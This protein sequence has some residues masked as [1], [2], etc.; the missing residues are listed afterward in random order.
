MRVAPRRVAAAA[1][2]CLLGACGDDA[3]PVPAAR[4]IPEPDPANVER[5]VFLVGD[6]GNARRESYPILT[7]LQQDVE[8]WASRLE[9]DS[10]VTVLFLGDNVYPLGLSARDSP[11]FPGDSAIL[12]DQV[13]LLAG[14]IARRRH[15][16]GYFVAGNH[17]WGLED[18]FEGFVR[19][20][21]MEE[22]L[23]R[24]RASTG[25]GVQ[26]VPRA[27]SG[28]PYVLDL[29]ESIRL[30]MLD[31]AWWLL[32]GGVEGA[33]HAVVLDSVEAA[34]RSAGDRRVLLVAHHPL[35]TAGAHG[36]A[37]SF[38]KTLGVRYLLVRSGAVLQDL[39]SVPYRDLERGL[40]EIFT[41][42]GA[43]L[44][45]IGGHD[46]SLQLLRGLEPT[47]PAFTIISGSA[48]KLSRVGPAEGLLF[49]RSAPGY[50]RLVVEKGGGVTLFVEA[51]P[52][53]FLSC[54]TSAPERSGCMANGVAAFETVHSQRLR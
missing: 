20:D 10:A 28:G 15:A 37:F 22:F 52:E 9:R 11:G 42:T 5:V 7:R 44:A 43:P 32:A 46:H 35:R 40:R 29:G 30:L 50:M 45:S 16:Q 36:G 12:M 13:R 34:M 51:A 21:R 24:A 1:L 19:L 23:R 54:P 39:T 49:A 8:G 27:G 18:E 47:D 53:Q 3:A 26:L 48:S 4:R 2:L 33:K 41:R 25:A 31:T 14:P 17:D 38:W 6:A